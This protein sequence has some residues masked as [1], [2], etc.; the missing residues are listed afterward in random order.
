L[1]INTWCWRPSLPLEY[2]SFEL[3]NSVTFDQPDA[4]GEFFRHAVGGCCDADHEDFV[5]EIATAIGVRVE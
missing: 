3:Q 2:E 1:T 5:I 4:D